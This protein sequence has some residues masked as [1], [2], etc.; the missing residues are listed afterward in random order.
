MLPLSNYDLCIFDCDGVIL[1]ANKIKLDA[2]ERAVLDAGF[3]ESQA[4]ACKEYF[5]SNFGKSRFVHIR[6]FVEEILRIEESLK[7]G[8][9]QKILDGFSKYCREQYV[10]ANLTPRFLELLS[11]LKGNKAVASGSEQTEL[12]ALFKA[13]GL[14]AHF[15]C[16][17]GSPTAKSVNVKDILNKVPHTRA[18]MVGDAKA[19]F[20]AAL[21]NNIDFIGYIPFSN[22]PEEM[23]ALSIDHGFPISNKWLS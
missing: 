20:E 23:K 13:R 4:L 21:E 14:A 1:D 5:A 17:L 22:V 19:D 3:S 6:Y 10:N 9:Y 11:S 8:T 12:R 18:V 16:I 2:M 15:E 7:D